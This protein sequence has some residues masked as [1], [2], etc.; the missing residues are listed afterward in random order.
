MSQRK[1][2]Y[3]K[4]NE[5][6]LVFVVSQ[7]RC[8]YVWGRSVMVLPPEGGCTSEIGRFSTFIFV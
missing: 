1:Y 6:T 8:C 4:S 2:H 3:E 7:W 5:I